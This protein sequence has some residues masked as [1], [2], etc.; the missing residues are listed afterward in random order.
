M[1]QISTAAH[2]LLHHVNKHI[3]ILSDSLSAIQ[4][5]ENLEIMTKPKLDCINNNNKIAVTNQLALIW[6]PGHSDIQGHQR[7]D[8]LANTGTVVE[9]I[10]PSPVP[11]IPLSFVMSKTK[12]WM[13][14]QSTLKWRYTHK[15]KGTKKFLNTIGMTSLD[16]IRN[17]QK[18]LLTYTIN[19]ITGHGPFRS[20]LIKLKLRDDYLALTVVQS[21]TH[22][23]TMSTTGLNSPKQQ[24]FLNVPPQ[25]PS[26]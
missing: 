23:C 26:G 13:T 11:A 16:R 17:L 1:F 22:R 18:P 10:G 12:E 24:T 5:L 6:V 14:D 4:S 15:F 8:E 20:R 7:A 9:Y 2:L 19:T 3:A 25:I 21:R